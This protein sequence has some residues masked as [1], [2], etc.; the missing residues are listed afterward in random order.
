MRKGS[1][2]I[3]LALLVA[4][5]S[6]CSSTTPQGDDG[7][8]LEEPIMTRTEQ[9]IAMFECVK[10]AG[11]EVTLIEETNGTGFG[12]ESSATEDPALVWEQVAECRDHMPP[13]PEPTT[14]EDLAQM[15]ANQV[16]DQ[17]C[18]LQ[19]GYPVSDP[20]SLESFKE[21]F[22]SGTLSW[23]PYSELVPFPPSALEACPRDPDR[24]W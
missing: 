2:F 15:Y 4:L 8:E 18:L 20:P 23:E 17:A 13:Q 24:W 5:L 19:A 1:L 10:E 12:M 16:A 3:S 7:G 6:G 14:D 11:F 22:H 9:Q 21:A